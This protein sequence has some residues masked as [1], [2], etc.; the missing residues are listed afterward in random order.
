MQVSAPRGPLLQV[1]GLKRYFPASGRAAHHA[2]I[3]AVEDVSF[4]VRAGETLGLVGESG[5]G[6]STTGRMIV[7]LDRPTAGTIAFRGQNLAGL[8]PKEWR[9]KRRDLQIVFQNPQSA[10]DPRLSVRR[11]IRE[12]LDLHG[13]GTASEREAT[14][15]DLMEAVS[16]PLE[17]GD[18]FP[19]EISGGQA[20]RV[21]IARALTLKPGLIV[22]DE[23]V[24]ALDVSVQAKVIALLEELQ[25]RLGVSYLFI[26]HDLRVVKMLCH[27]VA[28]M[29]LGQIVEEGLTDD[30]YDEPLHPYT[31]ALLSAIPDI[32]AAS[33][34]AVSR[35]IVLQGDPPSP[36]NPPAGCHFHTRCPF[37]RERCRVEMPLLRIIGGESETRRARCHFAEELKAVS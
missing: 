36:A 7:G 35:R 32:S 6:K 15:T 29:Y 18:R 19:H 11:Q 28:V 17:L 14:V 23:P 9:A 33:H 24:S 13:M 16:L 37:A 1:A 12:P 31:K 27:R 3:K 5:C 10:L 34:R 30:L 21:V 20:Q 26:S 22:C 2:P 8:S 4:Y 25:A